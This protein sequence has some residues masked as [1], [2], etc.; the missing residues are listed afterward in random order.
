MSYKSLVKILLLSIIVLFTSCAK[1]QETKEYNA[2]KKHPLIFSELDELNLKGK[3]KEVAGYIKYNNE[4]TDKENFYEGR[5]HYGVYTPHYTQYNKWGGKIKDVLEH[6][7]DTLTLTVT[8]SLEIFM[9]DYLDEEEKLSKY[10]DRKFKYPVLNPHP[11]ISNSRM[12][13]T[14]Q[15][16]RDDYW[17]YESITGFQYIYN[18]DGYPLEEKKFWVEDINHNGVHDEGE[19]KELKTITVFNYDKDNKILSKVIRFEYDNTQPYLLNDYHVEEFEIDGKS[20]TRYEYRYDEKDRIIEILLYVDNHLYKKTK[21]TYHT[22]GWVMKREIDAYVAGIMFHENGWKFV[23][24]LNKN[25]D[26]TKGWTYNSKG[27]LINERF[28]EYEEYDS[29]NNWL[30]CNLYTDKEKNSP[31]VVYKRRIE[32][33]ED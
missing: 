12:Y 4:D 31:A 11:V 10:I 1:S 27:E 24:E 3:V 25:G 21:Y 20:V 23:V 33:Y 7:V 30:K 14:R 19:E 8:D 5:R 15:I 26:F 13:T 22:E 2:E 28:Y 18:S 6:Y 32:Y 29:H 17:L 16:S 9:F